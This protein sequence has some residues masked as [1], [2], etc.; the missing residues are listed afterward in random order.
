MAPSRSPGWH[1][2]ATV[3]DASTSFRTLQAP[4]Q[5]IVA[6]T[7]PA[8]LSLLRLLMRTC[9]RHPFQSPRSRP[10]STAFVRTARATRFGRSTGP[11][12]APRGLRSYQ[13]DLLLLRRPEVM[14]ISRTD[15]SRDHAAVLW[16]GTTQRSLGDCGLARLDE[17]EECGP[18]TLTM[19]SVSAPFS[20]V[21]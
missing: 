13:H 10:A 7:A 12:P 1:V 11:W 19:T 18:S 16:S 14:W 4:Q 2:K 8:S 20:L 9:L 3:S 5:V 21:F 15:G 6:R 17:G